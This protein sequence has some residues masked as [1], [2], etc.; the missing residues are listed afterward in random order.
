VIEPKIVSKGQ[1]MLAGFSFF[2]DPFAA[3]GG[4]TEE[5]EIGRLWNRFMAFLVSH[6]SQL[7]HLAGCQVSYEVHIEHEET[8]EKGQYE[9]FAGVEVST[10]EGLP[11]QLSVKVLPAT[12]YAVFTLRGNDITSDWSRIIYQEWMA[13]SGYEKAY[14]FGFEAYDSRFKGLDRLA[15]SELDV[16]VPVRAK[17]D[18]R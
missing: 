14:A 11:V 12:E 4:W 5:N 3:S 9:V 8:A 18:D 13:G 6:G 7:P 2:G 10:I 17:R 16:F 1:I 15:E